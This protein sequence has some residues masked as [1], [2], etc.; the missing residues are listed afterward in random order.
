MISLNLLLD[1]VNEKTILKQI[2]K[3]VE[4]IRQVNY[5]TIVVSN[6]VGGGIVPDNEL[7]R[8]FR[9]IIGLANQI[10]A[11][12]A[13]EVYLVVSGIPIRLKENFDGEAER[14]HSGD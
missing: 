3:I 2:R 9:D 6:E 7:G 10:M 8:R 4:I 1:G 5:T 14:N 13:R 12:S 11:K